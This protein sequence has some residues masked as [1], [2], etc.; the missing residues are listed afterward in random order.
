MKKTRIKTNILIILLYLLLIL[1]IKIIII[2]NCNNTAAVFGISWTM[3]LLLRIILKR[4]E[5]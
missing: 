1:F 2:D 3:A 4:L 5:D